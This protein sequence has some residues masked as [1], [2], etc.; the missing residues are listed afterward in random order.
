MKRTPYHHF[1]NQSASVLFEK[2][3][4]NY[5]LLPTWLMWLASHRFGKSEAILAAA[6]HDLGVGL[7]GR[8]LGAVPAAGGD[9][10][11]FFLLRWCCLPA[12]PIVMD[13]YRRLVGMGRRSRSLPGDFARCLAIDSLGRES[14][15]ALSV[16]C[17]LTFPGTC[18]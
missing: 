4:A 8:G 14:L 1:L 3:E 15:M 9:G 13:Y 5:H 11:R 12:N 18:W 16:L 10:W 7:S 17:N 2:Y 6:E